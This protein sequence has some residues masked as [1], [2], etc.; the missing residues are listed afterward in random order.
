MDGISMN[1]RKNTCRNVLI[2]IA[3]AL[4]MASAVSAGELYPGKHVYLS[5]EYPSDKP[6]HVA[7]IKYLLT[8][9]RIFDPT[10]WRFQYDQHLSLGIVDLNDD[11]V[12]EA[13]VRSGSS[14]FCGN[15][16]TC[17]ASVYSLNNGQWWYAGGIEVRESGPLPIDASVFVEDNYYL[18]WRT[19]NDGERRYC[20][21]G[22]PNEEH[23]YKDYFLMPRPYQSPGYYGVAY[24][25]KPCGG[26]LE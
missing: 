5:Q 13:I 23:D 20:W 8:N 26:S 22:R 12:E 18:G 17:H 6:E 19:L 25:D 21:K 3:G 14:Y 7:L 2:G 11:G 16:V 10:E 4:F 15:K 1:N 24:L 9:L